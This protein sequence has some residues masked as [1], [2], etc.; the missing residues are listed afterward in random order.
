MTPEEIKLEVESIWSKVDLDGSGKI[1]YSEWVV[2][3]AN[4]KS[5]L[6]KSK[7][8]KAFELFDKVL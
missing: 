5:L 2:A 6:T 1:D 7:L 3:T 8:K 4:K